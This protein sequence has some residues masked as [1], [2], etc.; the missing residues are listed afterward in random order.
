MFRM[1]IPGKAFRVWLCRDKADCYP[2]PLAY[3][4]RRQQRQQR[5]LP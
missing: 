4:S 3:R 5:R 2:R 1:R